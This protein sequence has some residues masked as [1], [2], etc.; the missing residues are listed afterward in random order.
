M[1]NLGDCIN[2]KIQFFFQIEP[3]ILHP[4]H[5]FIYTNM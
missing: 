3:K 2:F 4:W 5:E 1:N